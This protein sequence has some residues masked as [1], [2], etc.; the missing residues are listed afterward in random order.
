VVIPQIKEVKDVVS[1]TVNEKLTAKGIVEVMGYD[2][3]IEGTDA[4]CGLWF[5]KEDGQE[6]KATVI[7]ENKPSKIIA[8]VPDLT[9]GKWHVKIVTQY[10]GGKVLKTPKIYTFPKLLTVGG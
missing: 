3:K 2:I 10:S 7:A 1:A 8:M 5:V 9:A 6:I 4:A